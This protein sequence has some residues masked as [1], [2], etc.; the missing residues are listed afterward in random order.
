M[1][2]RLQRVLRLFRLYQLLV[3]MKRKRAPICHLNQQRPEKGQ[4]QT[5][6]KQLRRTPTKFRQYTRLT[7]ENFDKLLSL[8]GDK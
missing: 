6:F 4:Y 2:A 3:V 8:V 7:V 1:F 5:L